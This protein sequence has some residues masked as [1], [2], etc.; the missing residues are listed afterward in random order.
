L[1]TV[2]TLI[3]ATFVMGN[4]LSGLGEYKTARLRR[5]AAGKISK[6][7]FREKKGQSKTTMIRITYVFYAVV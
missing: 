2:L 4:K 3:A 7:F 1:I 6:T 5:D